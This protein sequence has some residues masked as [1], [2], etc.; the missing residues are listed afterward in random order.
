MLVACQKDWTGRELKPIEVN[1]AGQ[2]VHI[3]V[4]DGVKRSGDA[5]GLVAMLDPTPNDGPSVILSKGMEPISA[6]ADDYIKASTDKELEKRELSGGHGG[7]FDRDGPHVHVTRKVGAVYI[8]C[9]AAFPGGT[10]DKAARVEMIWKMC[11]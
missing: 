11:K 9:D 10:K 3:S 2:K 7:V 8:D 1:L 6:T 4:P 5:N